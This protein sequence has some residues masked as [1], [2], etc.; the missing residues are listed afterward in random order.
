MALF[1]FL[2]N[3]QTDFPLK[4][5]AVDLPSR[6]SFLTSVFDRRL[7]TRTWVTTNPINTSHMKSRVIIINVLLPVSTSTLLLLIKANPWR[8]LPLVDVESDSTSRRLNMPPFLPGGSLDDM[9]FHA[10]L[11]S[12]RCRGTLLT[13][14]AVCV[15]TAPARDV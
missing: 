2:P 8:R 10:S 11:V 15:A 13:A 12:G 14:E 6:S 4:H 1:P 9:E 3:I 7:L 5:N